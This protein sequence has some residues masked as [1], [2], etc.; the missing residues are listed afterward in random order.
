ME[1]NCEQ[2]DVSD[3]YMETYPLVLGN[4]RQFSRNNKQNIDKNTNLK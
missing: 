1:K 4:H 2:N 3:D